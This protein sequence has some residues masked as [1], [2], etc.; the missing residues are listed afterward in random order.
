MDQRA[1]VARFID[2]NEAHMARGLLETNGIA[3]RLGDNNTVAADWGYALAIG[4]IKLMVLDQCDAPEARRLL[5]DVRSGDMRRALRR[6]DSIGVA[7]EDDTERCPACRS[8]DIFRA[9]SPLSAIITA[10]FSAP[11]LLSSRQRHCRAC[12]HE[13]T[14]SP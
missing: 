14:A 8:A 4:G 13:W 9:R 7:D 3:C 12:G 5:E 2:L 1:I 10:L 6:I 11:F